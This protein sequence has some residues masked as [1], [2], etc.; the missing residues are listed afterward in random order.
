M[1]RV[2]LL[3]NSFKNSYEIKIGLCS[4]LNV[5]NVERTRMPFSV[6]NGSNTTGVTTTSNHAQ[7]SSFELDGV[8]DFVGVDVQPNGIVHFDDGVGIT[9]GTTVRGVQVRD[10][11]G[12]GLDLSDTAQLIFSFL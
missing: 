7:V 4:Y 3:F 5:N 6:H 12:S 8:H 2:Q 9:D 1:I 10:I 11:L